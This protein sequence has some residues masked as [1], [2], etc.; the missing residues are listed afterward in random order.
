MYCSYRGSSVFMPISTV[1]EESGLESGTTSA[2]VETSMSWP[3][4]SLGN[5]TN[6]YSPG[7]GQ[8]GLQPPQFPADHAVSGLVD[9]EDGG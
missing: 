3:R 4:K 6:Q 8:I 7:M 2:R 5:V 9:R 1:D